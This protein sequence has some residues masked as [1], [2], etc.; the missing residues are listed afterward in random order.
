MKTFFCVCSDVYRWIVFPLEAEECGIV[1]K[2]PV[3][4]IMPENIGC[5]VLVK[6]R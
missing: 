2:K 5:N 1:S 3:S 4:L 6:I